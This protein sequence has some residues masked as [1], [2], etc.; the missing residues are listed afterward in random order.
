MTCTLCSCAL[1]GGIDTFGP[2]GVPVC[3]PCWFEVSDVAVGSMLI[4][5]GEPC[6]FPPRCFWDSAILTARRYFERESPEGDYMDHLG[7]L[8]TSEIIDAMRAARWVEEA[9]P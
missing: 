3:A 2:Y 9:T 1:S 4:S 5:N 7:L 8:P 6:A